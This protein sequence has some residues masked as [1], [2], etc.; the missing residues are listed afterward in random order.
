MKKSAVIE[1]VA[2]VWMVTVIGAAF[3]GLG[4]A[5]FNLITGNY[6]YPYI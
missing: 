1:M 3:I 6:I 5:V 4:V 2:A